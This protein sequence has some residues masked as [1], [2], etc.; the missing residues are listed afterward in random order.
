MPPRAH[1]GAH[2]DRP[3]AGRGARRQ[4]D[5]LVLLGLVDLVL[6]HPEKERL[7]PILLTLISE[8][9]RLDVVRYAAAAIVAGREPALVEGLRSRAGLSGRRGELVREALLLLPS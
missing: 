4:R 3:D 2:V 1:R 8:S 9:D 5:E 7:A 6:G